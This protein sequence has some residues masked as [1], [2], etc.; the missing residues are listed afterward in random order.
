[1]SETKLKPQAMDATTRL[2]SKTITITRDGTAAS[3]DVPYT[4]IGFVP[5]SIDVIMCINGTSYWSKGH[6]GSARDC[7]CI[8]GNGAGNVYGSGGYLI[9]YSN[10]SGFAQNAVVKTYDPDGFTLTYTKIASP[11]ANTMLIY[12]ICYR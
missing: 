1:M 7:N 4:G 9:Q 11:T 10:Q 2:A 8:Y 6:S 3:G 5:T 12:A